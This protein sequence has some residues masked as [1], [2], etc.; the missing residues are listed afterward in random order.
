MTITRQ[1]LPRRTFLRGVGTT[2]ALPLLDAMVPALTATTRTAAAPI[3]RLGFMYIPNGVI[4]EQWVPAATGAAFDLP[5]SLLPLAPVRDQVLVLSGLA[6]RQA[7]SMGDGNGDHNRGIAVWLSG[8]HAWNRLRNGGEA[9]LATTADQIA[10]AELGRHTQLPSLELS[11]E[12]PTQMACDSADCFFGNTLSWRTPTTPNHMESH[13]RVVFTRL[14]GD[15]GSP[16]ERREQRR[17]TGSILDSV[18]E[19]AR[20]LER[21]LGPADVSKLTEYLESVRDLERRIEA[22]ETESA[23]VSLDL[24]ERPVDVPASLYD[25]AHLMFDLQVLAWR[26]DITR[27]FSML[28]GLEGTNQP[29]PDIGV[30]EGHH[31]VSH[32]RYDPVLIAK[33]AKIDTFHVQLFAEFL[34]KLRAIPEGDGTL[35]DSS[36]VLCGSG[37]GDGNAHDHINLPT[38][39]GGGAGVFRGGRHLQYPADTPMTNLLLTMLDTAGVP[40][41]E[42][43]GDS[44]GRLSLA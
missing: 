43:I 31:G 1:A 15:G 42:R 32:H 7:D 17:R 2:I 21:L 30:P 11:L 19:E 8:V 26:A 22:A 25:Y 12:V 5:P 33:K 37:L 28:I 40:L 44:S 10:A 29:Y 27:V 41:P 38:L 18:V 24:P 16:A 35:L 39:L 6:H 4:H 3:R 9:T 20:Q 13:P 36:A 14:F 23:I 34:G